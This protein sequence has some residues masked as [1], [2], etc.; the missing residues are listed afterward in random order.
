MYYLIKCYP[1]M[2]FFRENKWV[3]LSFTDLSAYS[4]I[5]E[6]MSPK[7]A[8][9]F[10]NEISLQCMMSLRSMGAHIELYWGLYDGCLWSAR[11]NG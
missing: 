7:V 4:T 10:H 8:V 9:E 3:T 11:G 1:M 5:I 6:H 2:V